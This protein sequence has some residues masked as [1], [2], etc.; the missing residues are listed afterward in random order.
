MQ[1][2]IDATLYAAAIRA[3]LDLG[4]RIFSPAA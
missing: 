4:Q 3:V 1:C 2:G